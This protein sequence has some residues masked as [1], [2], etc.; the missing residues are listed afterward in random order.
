VLAGRV[1]LKGNLAYSLHMTGDLIADRAG[2]FRNQITNK[3]AAPKCQ[4]H[5]DKT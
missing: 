4:W 5:S 3:A 2:I 1:N